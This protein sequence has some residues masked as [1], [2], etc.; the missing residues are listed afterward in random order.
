MS[1]KWTNPEQPKV[2]GQGEKMENSCTVDFRSFME[3][4]N[5]HIFWEIK[6]PEFTWEYIS[7]S[8]KKLRGYTVKDAM[9]R[10]LQETLTVKSFQIVSEKI[11]NE[12]LPEAN[13]KDNQIMK[14]E[15]FCK[16][17]STKWFSVKISVIRNERGRPVKI[18]G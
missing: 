7:P 8:I 11:K 4:F 10:S 3:K 17:G 16:N 2:V 9:K 15:H 5:K 12:L 13:E 1:W 6:L 14:L 18:I